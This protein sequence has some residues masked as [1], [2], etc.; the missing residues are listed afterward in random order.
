MEPL[1][2]K[3]AAVNAAKMII[4]DLGLDIVDPS[5]RRLAF[6][7][8]VVFDEI[9]TNINQ[10]N[11]PKALVNVYFEMV[12]GEYLQRELKAGRLEPL[13][14]SDGG[15]DPANVT[16]VKIGDITVGG[17]AGTSKRDEITGVI[18]ALRNPRNKRYLF[19]IHRVALK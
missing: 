12:A 10:K 15:I 13:Y 19:D 6:C 16:S 1:Q 17:N 11:I 18:D 3:H 7:A 5:P 8:A 9:T 14:E 2:L 4:E